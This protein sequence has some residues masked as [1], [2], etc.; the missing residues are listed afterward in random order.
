MRRIGVLMNLAEHD[1]E[2]QA[3][4]GAFRDGLQLLGWTVGRNVRIDTRWGGVRADM[5][6]AGNAWLEIQELRQ[7][8]FNQRNV[9]L[10]RPRHFGGAQWLFECPDTGYRVTKLYWPPG[11][12]CLPA[13]CG[14]ALIVSLIARSSCNVAA[15]NVLRHEWS[16]EAGCGAQIGGQILLGKTRPA[17]APAIQV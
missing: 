7:G 12:H 3:R 1:P 16:V 5:R 6:D 13:G 15:D 14:G 2:G 17:G 10:T 11:T 4:V 9:L 8:G